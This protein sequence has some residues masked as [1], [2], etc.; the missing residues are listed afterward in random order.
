MN[1]HD[2]GFKD[3]KVDT[4]KRKGT[5]EHITGSIFTLDGYNLITKVDVRDVKFIQDDKRVIV[6]GSDNDI[7]M[8][9]SISDISGWMIKECG[10]DMEEH[11]FTIANKGFYCKML[12]SGYKEVG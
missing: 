8:D 5:I 6:Y 9:A 3:K 7:I 10:E 11:I 12:V 1:L 4:N 2:Y